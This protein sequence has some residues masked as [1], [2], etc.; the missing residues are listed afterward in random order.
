MPKYTYVGD[1]G[2]EYPYLPPPANGPEVGHTYTLEK[3]PADDRWTLLVPKKQK[4]NPPTEDPAP[5][6]DNQ[7]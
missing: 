1:A 7:E 5:A 6:G 3:A 2:R 4:D